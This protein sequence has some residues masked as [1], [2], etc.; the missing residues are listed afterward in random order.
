MDCVIIHHGIK[1]QRWGVRRFKNKDGTLTSQG[2]ARYSDTKKTKKEKIKSIAKGTARLAF[3]TLFLFAPEI[4]DSY[5]RGRA[6]VK[7][8]NLMVDAYAE[9]K[10]GLNA[11]N[12]GF[13]LG[14]K[15]V[16]NGKRIVE[17]LL[18]GGS[19]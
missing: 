13:T 7:A 18:K 17:S 16:S 5:N 9:A 8:Q 15:Q 1:G 3:G 4:I 11:I 14:A 6:Y 2:K 12:A 19:Q 10:G